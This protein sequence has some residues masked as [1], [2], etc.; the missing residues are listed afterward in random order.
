MSRSNQWP[1]ITFFLSLY[2]GFLYW[3]YLI[4]PFLGAFLAFSTFNTSSRLVSIGFFHALSFLSIFY[5]FFLLALGWIGSS[6]RDSI[7]GQRTIDAI[8]LMPMGRTETLSWLKMRSTWIPGFLTLFGAMVYLFI[9]RLDAF[10]SLLRSAPYALASLYLLSHLLWKGSFYSVDAGTF[11]GKVTEREDNRIFAMNICFT[12]SPLLLSFLPYQAHTILG[13]FLIVIGFFWG[14]SDSHELQSFGNAPILNSLTKKETTNTFSALTSIR[15]SFFRYLHYR[16]L[17][18]FQ[19]PLTSFLIQL[20]LVLLLTTLYYAIGGL[21][22]VSNDI[23]LFHRSLYLSFLVCFATIFLFHDG[24]TTR[25]HY[26]IKLLIPLSQK[27]KIVADSLGDTFITG[28]YTCL[29]LPIVI[30]FIGI[31]HRLL[32]LF[33]S[34][35]MIPIDRLI[36]SS[37]GFALSFFFLSILSFSLIDSFLT[38]LIVF[39]QKISFFKTG[40][41]LHRIGAFFLYLIPLIASIDLKHEEYI[42]LER[43]LGYPMIL[44][45][46][47]FFFISQYGLY[48][49]EKRIQVIHL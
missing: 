25:N 19:Y 20:V 24:G 39:F 12:V 41:W 23:S 15:P 18:R 31:S 34:Q 11:V 42:S 4:L 47:V 45:Y 6:F 49:A 32:S 13:L 27:E 17:S 44:A 9:A 22:L 16:Y 1:K 8:L 33:T 37:A 26:D 29:N 40:Y 14:E 38:S 10:Y 46:F 2:P 35:P 48:W 21:Y 7:F 36:I 3:R 43:F 28:L 5:V 30:F